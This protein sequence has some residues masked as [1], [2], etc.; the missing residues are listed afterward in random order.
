[1]F[2]MFSEKRPIEKSITEQEVVYNAIKPIFEEIKYSLEWG[3]EED[4]EGSLLPG[5]VDFENARIQLNPHLEKLD[6]EIQKEVNFLIDFL[7]NAGNLLNP[8][9]VTDVLENIRLCILE[10]KNHTESLSEL[11]QNLQ[12][13]IDKQ[14]IDN[15]LGSTER[16][17]WGLALIKFRNGDSES[18]LSL[19]KEK[20][21]AEEDQTQTEEVA[22]Y[23][24]LISRG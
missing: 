12:S 6:L 11:S 20:L 13:F 1:M 22:K 18:I 5:K 9:M 23:I 7:E 16:S 3:G 10:S 17:A 15:P 19:L 4:E 21:S 14:I 2:D 24:E 8:D